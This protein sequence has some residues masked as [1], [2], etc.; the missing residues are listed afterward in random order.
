MLAVRCLVLNSYPIDRYFS[1]HFTTKIGDVKLSTNVVY[2]RKGLCSLLPPRMLP[3]QGWAR[4]NFFKII[5]FRSRTRAFSQIVPSQFVLF[6]IVPS[7]FRSWSSQLRTVPS[8]VL[9]ICLYNFPKNT[10]QTLP[11][12]TLV[13]ASRDEKQRYIFS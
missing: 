6:P 9:I 10:H 7:P 13:K 3:P 8:Q 12:I 1:V 5:P 4:S 2:G 11:F